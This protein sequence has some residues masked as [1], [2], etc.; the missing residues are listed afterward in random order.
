LDQRFR[1]RTIGPEPDGATPI[2]EDDLEG[3]IPE[4]VATRSDLNQV[5]YENIAKAMPWAKSRARRLGP[6]GVLD[7]LF[8]FDLHK[9]MFEDVWRWAGARRR[10]ETNIGVAPHQIA[11][12]V[13]TV[14]A[15]ARYWHDN[16]VFSAQERA[17][18]LHYRLVCV[19]PFPNR[20]GRTTRLIADLYLDLLGERPLSWGYAELGNETAIRERYIATL[21]R[22]TEDDCKSL[23]AFAQT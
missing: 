11:V 22:G 16:G 7:R 3:L 8:L 5:E 13:E 6:V 4:F 9:H 21:R 17:V 12:A 1:L 15:D 23:V 2:D 20:N 10:H 18:R 14:L 19:H